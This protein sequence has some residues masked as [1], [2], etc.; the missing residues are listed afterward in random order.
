MNR[1]VRCVRLARARW[2][3]LRHPRLTIGPGTTLTGKLTIGGRGRI[4]VGPNCRIK[5]ATL[6][7]M[8]PDSVL[9]IGRDCYLNGPEIAAQDSVVVGDRCEIGSAM[10]F[11]TDFHPVQ[12][13]PRGEVRVAPIVIG[14]DVWIAART[15]VLRGVTIGDRVVVG[16]GAVVAA[17]VPADTLVRP[18]EPRTQPLFAAHAPAPR[19]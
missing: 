3:A 8:G 5:T 10:I 19:R 1:L 7:A 13:V 9:T 14:D 12:R 11:D 4:V 17:S 18:G 6:W 15:A 16:L 2:A